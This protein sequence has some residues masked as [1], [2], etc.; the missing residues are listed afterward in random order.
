MIMLRGISVDNGGSEARV[1]SC[2]SLDVKCMD[3]DFMT[4]RESDFRVK[5]V[6]DPSK[7][8]R[9]LEAPKEDFKGIIAQGNTGKAYVNQAIIIS[10]QESKTSDINYYKQFIF[11]VA[12]DAISAWIRN[13]GYSQYTVGNDIS[14]G[15][16]D[17]DS[18][19]K[20]VIVSC[21]PIKEFNGV[22]DC[23]S[24]LKSTLAGDYK[25]EFPLLEGKPIIRF[26]ISEELTGVVPEGGVAIMGL[27]KELDPEDI[28]LVIDMGHI[29]TDIGL[30]QGSGLLG[31]VVSSQFAGSTIL[32]NL[33]VALADEGYILTESQLEK[34]LATKIV[35]NGKNL[36]DVT[37]IVEAEERD[38]VHN[39]LYKDILNVLNMNKINVKQIQNF[40]PIGAPMNNPSNNALISEIIQCCKLE[41]AEVKIL[42]D[43]LRYVNVMQA[44]KFAKV[45]LNKAR[46]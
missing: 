11:N 5:D 16:M 23:A 29:T 44:N 35:K 27:K 15:V 2:D 40:I 3:N 34:V 12:Q 41:N 36:V 30:F 46:K 19:F 26:N 38:F 33:R 4:I 21:I 22:K 6:V 13:G 8:C 28:S 10:S 43:D 37:D 1:Q 14:K 9:V 17:E 18:V 25:V 7:L 31:K 32:A 45:L 20:Y 24:I 39:Y 42:A